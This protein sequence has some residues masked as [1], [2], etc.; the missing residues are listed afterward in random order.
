MTAV[1]GVEFPLNEMLFLALTLVLTMIFVLLAEIRKLHGLIKMEKSDVGRFEV[2]LNGLEGRAGPKPENNANIQDYIQ[3]SLEKGIS[4]SDI[5]Q[6][7]LDRGW[8]AEQIDKVM[9]A[10]NK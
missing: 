1:F 9:P 8:K 10:Q 4:A 6:K 5:R 2:D 7:L 3:K